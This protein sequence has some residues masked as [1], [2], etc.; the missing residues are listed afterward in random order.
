MN[1]F[2]RRSTFSTFLNALKFQYQ[3][4]ITRFSYYDLLVHYTNVT[5]I[6]TFEDII[7]IFRAHRNQLEILP[8]ET[9]H[10]KTS[11]MLSAL[12][13]MLEKGQMKQYRSESPNKYKH[14]LYQRII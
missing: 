7:D 3:N 9:F 10:H 2:E 5:Q 13:Q 6:Y 14:H 8:N 12:K 4:E 1:P 11:N